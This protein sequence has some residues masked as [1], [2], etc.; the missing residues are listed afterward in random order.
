MRTEALTEI[1]WINDAC[2]VRDDFTCI[3][4][5][6][7]CDEGAFYRVYGESGGGLV[8]V[9]VVV[10][11]NN[12]GKNVGEKVES[13]SGKTQPLL[14]RSEWVVRLMSCGLWVVE[15]CWNI[16]MEN[17]SEMPGGKDKHST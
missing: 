11:Q 4:V 10:V 7:I 6:N 15:Y 13:V 1:Y 5:E 17:S 9:M 3:T 12:D 16:A 8:V 14:M 2:Y